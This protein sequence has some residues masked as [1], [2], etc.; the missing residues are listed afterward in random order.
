MVEIIKEMKTFDY[1]LMC[2]G[3][4]CKKE[5]RFKAAIFYKGKVYCLECRRKLKYSERRGSIM[6]SNLMR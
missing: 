6:A 1:K 3:T 4:D 5:L 2:S